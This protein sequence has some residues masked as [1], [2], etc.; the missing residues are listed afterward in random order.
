[1]EMWDNF[2]GSFLGYMAE[3]EN[4][5]K[6]VDAICAGYYNNYSLTARLTETDKKYI[7]NAVY[8][9]TGRI[10]NWI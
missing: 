9:R 10:I 4:L 2:D 7:S 3:C 1:M 5:D 6:I 8:R